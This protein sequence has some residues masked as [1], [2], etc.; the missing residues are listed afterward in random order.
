M[1]TLDQ[2]EANRKNAQLATGPKT[3]EGKQIVSRNAVTHGCSGRHVIL[4]GEDSAA[5]D[6]LLEGFRCQFGN[7]PV[8]ETLTAKM[9]EARWLEVRI[10]TQ[11]SHL[12]D[13]HDGIDSM[14]RM[15]LDRLDAYKR[16]ALRKFHRALGDIMALRRLALREQSLNSKTNPIPAKP[17]PISTLTE[18]PTPEPPAPEPD[19]EPAA[20]DP[21]PPVT[22]PRA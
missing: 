4:P 16:T 18:P 10:E 6:K 8:I 9:A 14:G 2:I 7:D 22:E 15:Q 17:N 5:F 21:E 11:E 13:H 1:S 20:P 19:P 3:P 12:W